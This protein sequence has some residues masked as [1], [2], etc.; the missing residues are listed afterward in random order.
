L[1]DL[2]RAINRAAASDPPNAALQ[3][4]RETLR[5]L[6]GVLGIDLSESDQAQHVEAAPFIELLLD[7]RAE[8]RAAK[9]WDLSDRI[10]DGLAERGITIED[11][12][13]GTT[14]NAER[15]YQP[16]S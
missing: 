5:E 16:E 6:A 4:A 11:G 14:W 1:F 2:G 8:L 10:R 3:T 15:T 12:P 13:T 7:V 9:Q